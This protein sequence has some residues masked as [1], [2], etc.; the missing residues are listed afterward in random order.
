[1]T[2]FNSEQSCTCSSSITCAAKLCNNGTYFIITKNYRK[3]RTPESDYI[4]C[5]N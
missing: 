3:Y 5:L 2:H 1:M 4:F